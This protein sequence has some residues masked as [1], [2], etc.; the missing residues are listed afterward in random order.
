MFLNPVGS[1]EVKHFTER[2]CS[3]E[4]MKIIVFYCSLCC[5]GEICR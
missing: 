5:T 3:E 1:L 2:D 4:L